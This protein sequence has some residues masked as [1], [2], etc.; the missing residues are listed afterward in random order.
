MALSY[1][2]IYNSFSEI[3]DTMTDEELASLIRAVL[4]YSNG[5]EA[6]ELVGGA[7][8]VFI[9]LKQQI[10]RDQQEYEAMIERQKAN[11]SKGGRPR[12]VQDNS[13]NQENPV[14]FEETQKSQ[15]KEEDK[16][17][18]KD[19]EEDEDKDKRVTSV[20]RKREN[21][22]FNNHWLHSA[23]ARAATAQQICDIADAEHLPVSS[24]VTLHSF[25][26]ECMERGVPPDKILETARRVPS[27]GHFSSEIANIIAAARSRGRT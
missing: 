9:M 19:K 16:D 13:E 6:R 25:C 17:K 12:K 24:M 2:K 23:A 22:T 5:G 4:A 26:V 3:A 11:G 14:V 1:T 10:D 8:Y 18:E 20:T 15:E 21:K 27:C 7:K